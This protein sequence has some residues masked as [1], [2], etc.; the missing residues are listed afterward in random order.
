MMGVNSSSTRSFEDIPDD[1]LVHVFQYLSV[2]DKCRCSRFVCLFSLVPNTLVRDGFCLTSIILGPCQT[3]NIIKQLCWATLL[4]NKVA[5][6]TS[7]VA[8]ILTSWVTK[9]SAADGGQ[10]CTTVP[11]HAAPYTSA[12]TAWTGHCGTGNQWRWSR[13]VSL[14]WSCFLVLT[15]DG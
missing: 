8:H 14:M 2:K 15:D 13:N 1:L 10:R 4:G 9:L 12:G 7:R 11:V 6:L 5:C 3:R